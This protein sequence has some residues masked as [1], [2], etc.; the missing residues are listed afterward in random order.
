M[1]QGDLQAFCCFRKNAGFSLG[2]IPIVTAVMK[3]LL[4]I[5]DAK[6][7]NRLGFEPEMVQVLIKLSLEEKG[8][9]DFVG[10]RQAVMYIIM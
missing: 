4:K 2:K 6:S 5:L 7:I 3:G 1:V 10:L 9:K 8:V